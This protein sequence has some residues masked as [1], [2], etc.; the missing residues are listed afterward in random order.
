MNIC[1]VV[2]PVVS[3]LIGALVLSSSV[4]SQPL[5][6]G[7]TTAAEQTAIDDLREWAATVAANG[8]SGRPLPAAGHWNTGPDFNRL[9]DRLTESPG[10]V[11]PLWREGWS[12]SYMAGQIR[13]GKRV[14]IS[15][16]DMSNATTTYYE[17]NNPARLESFF[18]YYVRPALEYAKQHQLPIGFVGWNWENQVA[19]S[20]PQSGQGTAWLL[21]NGQPTTQVDPLSPISVWSNWGTQWMGSAML[22][23]IQE[24]Y[25]NPPLV[26]FFNNNEGGLLHAASELGTN[27]DRFN[28]LHPGVTDL[29]AR[30]A[31]IRQGY[32]ERYAAMLGAARASFL[33]EAWRTNTRFVAYNAWTEAVLG[34]GS[35]YPVG[36]GTDLWFDPAA[37]KGY[38]NWALYD[39]ALPEFYDNQWQGEKTDYSPWSPQMESFNLTALQDKVFGERP[40]FYFSS[41]AWE[42]GRSDI[43]FSKVNNYITGGFGAGTQ[44]WDADRYQGMLQFGLWVMRPRDF[45]EFRGTD[46]LDGYNASTWGAVL[47]ATEHVWNNATLRD[48]WRFGTLVPN[49]TAT[50]TLNGHY[51]DNNAAWPTWLK[52][53]PRWFL[54]TS[55]ANP[56]EATW[57]RN[58]N[59]APS[60][61][62]RV[63]AIALRRGSAPDRRWLVYAH[64][65]LG[66]VAGSQVTIP[67]FGPVTLDY[68]PQSGSFFE[69]RESGGAVSALLRGGPAEIEV[70][71]TKQRVT[72]GESFTVRPKVTSPLD[73]PFSSFTWTGAGEP[74][75]QV[76]LADRSFSFATPG[77]YVIEVEG[78]TAQGA[79]VAGQTVVYVGPAP[80]DD[81]AYDLS[82][83]H[84]SPWEGLWSADGERAVRYRLTPNAAEPEVGVPVHGASF[85]TDAERG[86]VLQFAREGDGV[87]M[88]TSDRTT[89]LADGHENLTISFWFKADA[90]A[91]LQGLFAQGFAS[92]DG[93]GGF[94]LYLDGDRLFAGTWSMTGRPEAGG[95]VPAASAKWTGQWLSTASG[96][97]Q[98][99]KWHQV[100]LVLRDATDQVS[101]DKLLLYVD[102]SFVASGP[103]VRVKRHWIH[104]RLGFL[105]D[106]RL[107]SGIVDTR[108]QFKGRIDDFRYATS[109]PRPANA[110]QLKTAINAGGPALV[111]VSGVSYSADSG[112]EGGTVRTV[113]STAPITGGVDP[114]VYRSARQGNAFNY[115]LPVTN[116]SYRVVLKFAEL[117]HN[118]SGLRRFSVTAEGQSVV[119]NL[120]LFATRGFG[121]GY[122]VEFPVTIADGA[123]NLAF[124]ASVGEA[125]VG[126]IQV[127]GVDG[128]AVVVHSI[129]AETDAPPVIA[130]DVPYEL[131]MKFR[132]TEAGEIRAIRYFRPVG[133]TG[134]Q[135][136]RIWAQS[137]EQLASVV[138][139]GQSSSGWQQ[140]NL[141]TPLA[142]SP[143]QT[144][145][146]SVN[147]NSAYAF[148]SQ[149]FTA[150]RVSGPLVAP[151]DG[152]NGVYSTSVGTRPT[153]TYQGSDYYRDVVFAATSATPP[154][155]PPPPSLASTTTV[156]SSSASTTTPGTTLT[157]Q[158]SVT[159]GSGTP[160]GTVTFLDGSTSIGTAIL[161][162]GTGSLTTASLAVGAHTLTARYEGTATYATSVSAPLTH[163]VAKSATT[164][165]LTNQSNPVAVGATLGLTATVTGAT[166]GTVTFYDD[167]TVLGSAPLSGG[168]ATFTTS[169]AA[170]GTYSLSAGFDGSAVAEVSRSAALSLVVSAAL[171]QVSVVAGASAAA[172]FGTAPATFTIVRTGS[173][174][175]ALSVPFTLSG[176]ATVTTDYSVPGSPLVIPAGASSAVVTIVPVADG[177]PEGLESITLTIPANSAAYVLTTATA[178][179]NLADAPYDAWRFGQFTAEQLGSATV[180][181]SQA[182]PDSDGV[183]NLFEYLFKT[184]P[185][186]ANQGILPIVSEATVGTL[187]YREIS[188]PQNLAATDLEWVVEVASAGGSWSSGADA[189]AVQ[190]S[191][192]TDGVTVRVVR[193]S[194]A[195]T[196]AS[197]RL[198]RL[199]V[200]W[201][202]VVLTA[203]DKEPSPGLQAAYFTG[204]ALAGTPVLTRIDSTL[205]FNWAGGSP[206][207]G[208]PVDRFSVRWTGWIK[209]TH[210]QGDQVYTFFI[211]SDDGVR[212]WVAGQSLVNAWV[213][214][215]A[216]ER[217]GQVTL[218]AGKLYPITVEY[219]ERTGNAL[220][221]LSWSAAGLTKQIVPASALFY[222]AD[223]AS[224]TPP[225]PLARETLLTTQV[226]VIAS[227]NDGVAYELGLQFMT[228]KPG[229]AVAIRFW[230]PVNQTTA[231]VGRLYSNSGTVLATVNFP[232]KAQ[233]TPA[234]WRELSLATPVTLQPN[235]PYVVSVTT[236]G[237]YPATVDAF[238][239]TFVNGSLRTHGGGGLYG[240]VGQK[241]VNNYNGSN[242]FRDVVFEPTP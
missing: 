112:F 217:Q 116:G 220:A 81:V 200:T 42:G 205:N 135:T 213:G 201:G 18:D 130:Q 91:G 21:R 237:P 14:L 224:V 1:H 198:I 23:R 60:I 13:Q 20:G 211:R 38:R 41:I 125:T 84:G 26:W 145:T 169:F 56:A 219:F 73:Q 8:P 51:F 85:V 78:R 152:N 132:V 7:P 136:G 87:T 70:S 166:T 194:T 160:T 88:A 29:A 202:T 95:S 47:N 62:L 215:S 35:F 239:T 197:P 74:L 25:P 195:T 156:L 46:P 107:A 190:S 141:A 231:A 122:D 133:E 12:P 137:G 124:S 176:S 191:T 80:S 241:P 149:G 147:S 235:T 54:L 228:D 22:R 69:V 30:A 212:L 173:T 109:S 232:A 118:S 55:N 33:S 236:T 92:G 4:Y 129:F 6:S 157:L 227:A 104:P 199:K 101:P 28:A 177:V 31:I 161:T 50:A 3:A 121:G 186:A 53:T 233:A 234:G 114:D 76:T 89:Y 140:A 131:G 218:T 11:T 184:N 172:E 127:W 90:L 216:T 168:T 119:Q 128:P 96:R 102:D 97:I 68:V 83:D 182:D 209:P 204:E 82:F 223:R 9:I 206:G 86:S 72:V 180:S 61:K 110:Y 138:F 189:T 52:N 214:Q 117:D 226:P 179:T 225:A 210:A 240:P 93:G 183:V 65:P 150:D 165:V 120:D 24:I 221:Q 188:F 242:Y 2:R 57:D 45:R 108:A 39:G 77:E 151:A 222:L 27:A 126:A 178:S 43:S 163:T 229:R 98:A 99:G 158:A 193:D 10:G 238:A 59:N 17:A 34:R 32:T 139:T 106:T 36:D 170:A 71:T 64:A 123:L 115:T 49:A 144:Y 67:D 66:A 134:S 164:T 143:G 40:N 100:R 63:M 148:K 111:G 175:Q 58:Q 5:P 79:R 44:R 142:V 192:T 155:P 174:A 19:W 159:S 203:G 171:P 105:N 94:N 196:A 181:G 185:L 167:T 16:A 37:D 208:V 153:T 75:T 162:A 207:T 187:R 230:N 113:S 103:A 48:Y 146:V 154:P 15:F